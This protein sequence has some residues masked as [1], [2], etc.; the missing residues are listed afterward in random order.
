MAGP[1]L[2]AFF[3][4]LSVKRKEVKGSEETGEH[5]LSFIV[6]G[7][8][9]LWLWTVRSEGYQGKMP[10]VRRGIYD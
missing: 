2:V 6:S 4:L 3:L 5:G 7:G 8:V 9:F 10:E 1:I